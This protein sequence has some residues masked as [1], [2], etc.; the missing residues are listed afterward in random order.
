MCPPTVTLTGSLYQPRLVFSSNPMLPYVTRT[1]AGWETSVLLGPA[2][3]LLDGYELVKHSRLGGESVARLQ[4]PLMAV[5]RP[6]GSLIVLPRLGG[7]QAA[8]DL[9]SHAAK[10]CPGDGWFEIPVEAARDTDPARI[11]R[12]PMA[13]Q[14]L[15]QD[16]LK[17]PDWFGLELYDFQKDAAVLAASGH[18][19]IAEPMGLGKTRIALAAA[20]C[21]QPKKLLIVTPPVMIASWE[22]EAATS[23]IT[24][25]S[26]PLVVTAK[27][28]N[29]ELPDT[30]TIITT[31]TL[32]TAR[33]AL[34]TALTNWQPDVIIIDEAH[35]I[36]NPKSKRT[37]TILN[38][39]KNTPG[40][41]YCLT[42]TPMLA[43]PVELI[44][45]LQATRTMHWFKNPGAFLKTYTNKTPWGQHIA[46]KKQLPALKT[47]LDTHVWIRHPQSIIANIP[48]MVTQTLTINPDLTDYKQAHS[49]VVDAILDWAN[50]LPN[51]P[52]L[53][54]IDAWCKQSLPHISRLRIA[55]GRCKIPAAKDLILDWLDTHPANPDTGLF[56]NPLIVW[57]HHREVMDTLLDATPANIEFSVI[58]GGTNTTNT[59]SIVDNFQN[60]HT[61]LLYASIHAAGVGVTLTRATHALF[62]ETDW[63]PAI[64][65][66]AQAR[67]RRIGQ[68][69]TTISQTLVAPG[70]LDQSILK[71]LGGK[72]RILTPVL[73]EGQDVRPQDHQ[74]VEAPAQVI[75]RQLVL[76]TLTEHNIPIPQPD[77]TL[78]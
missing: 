8:W 39:T 76:G 29:P 23:G 70:T 10:W 45:L 68:T 16:G 35:R 2:S 65:A 42:G 19:L 77:N 56:D 46:R 57:C 78:F 55:A 9:L 38:L 4:K 40:P 26:T 53:G 49:E 52:S 44:P 63:T 34:A 28:R 7:R 66:Q 37:K 3:R 74:A 6:T 73:G 27:T 20:A 59:A 58:R 41:C 22:K 24:P 71:T 11:L 33:P 21:H 75:L 18:R 25:D 69:K 12:T 14:A 67:I 13:V 72:A 47:T 54:L 15:R 36:K 51:P 60:G 64:I 30:S 31:D 5:H 43:T 62:V 17:V 32:L 61:P 48:E 50:S 1:A